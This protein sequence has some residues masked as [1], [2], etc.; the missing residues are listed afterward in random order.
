[1]EA[2]NRSFQQGC[3]PQD[4]MMHVSFFV[5]WQNRCTTWRQSSKALHGFCLFEGDRPF[6]WWLQKPSSFFGIA[7]EAAFGPLLNQ[8]C[9]SSTASQANAGQCMILK[10]SLGKSCQPFLQMQQ[11]PEVVFTWKSAIF[12]CFVGGACVWP[13]PQWCLRVHSDHASYAS[14]SS[15]RRIYQGTLT[16]WRKRRRR[17]PV[18]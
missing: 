3:P 17:S 4:L 18:R 2:Y 11:L 12:T 8:N 9:I 14:C 13:F 15:L 6:F 10:R 1:M 7:F 16:I 5:K